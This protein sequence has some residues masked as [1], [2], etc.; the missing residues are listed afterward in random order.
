M[1]DKQGNLKDQRELLKIKVKVLAA[2]ARQIR[3]QER[4]HYGPIRDAMR[5]HRTTVVRRE[6]RDSHIAYALIKGREYAAIEQPREGN[7]PQWKNIYSM[8][9]RYGPLGYA[10]TLKDF[11]DQHGA[12]A[13]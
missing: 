4:K 10:G 11:I 8:F 6:A 9:R 2:E 3:Q 12:E 1:Y 7:P 5:N 13:T